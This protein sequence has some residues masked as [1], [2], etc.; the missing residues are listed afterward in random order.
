MINKTSSSS[1][2]LFLFS[3]LTVL[4]LLYVHGHRQ[5]VFA[6]DHL[7]SFAET[8]G[9]IKGW[10]MF[11]WGW[12]THEYGISDE[13]FYENKNCAF[14]RSTVTTDFQSMGDLQQKFKAKHYRNKRMR[15]SA[16]VKLEAVDMSAALKMSIQNLMGQSLSYDNM[17]G[18]N[19]SETRDWQTYK[20]VLDVPEESEYIDFGITVRG[21][22]EVW[23]SSVTFEETKDKP[24]AVGMYA[25]DPT[26]LEF[27]KV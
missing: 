14:I 3:L 4:P 10:N 26:N 21:R 6:P 24:T 22:G 19:I 13:T 9:P 23:V 27:S 5:N 17:Y 8:P 11:S 12:P 18:R 1:L 20:I 15:F 2:S 7:F 16:A 25:D